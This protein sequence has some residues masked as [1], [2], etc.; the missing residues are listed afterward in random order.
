MNVC[1]LPFPAL[2]D[3]MRSSGLVLRVGPF[4][5]CVHTPFQ[6]LAGMIHHLY[7]GHECLPDREF[8]DFH[9]RVLPCRDRS[10]PWRIRARLVLDG[11]RAHRSFSPEES[12][13]Y[14]EWGLNWCI[15]GHAHQ[16]LILHSAVVAKDDIALIMPGSSGAGKS[17]LCA[18]L[19]YDGWR[20]LSDELGLLCPKTGTIAALARPIVLKDDAI[21][22]FREYA[23]DAL[24]GPVIELRSQGM[25]GALA[26][27]PPESVA[28]A[29]QAA[30]PGVIVFPNF[31][32][33]APGQLTSVTKGQAFLRIAQRSFNFAQLGAL[34]F[35][36]IC[37]LID[38]CDCYEF[39][40]SRLEDALV[41]F[42]NLRLSSSHHAQRVT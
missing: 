36:A 27:V 39:T 32:K 2:A 42:R 22:A 14:F 37:R 13:A 34:G 20:L 26:K 38:Q 12:I 5:V 18:A 33:N 40:Y 9:I 24:W 6:H 10:Q 31:Q 3:R 25:R 8:S 4:T 19:A 30:Y 1:H 21:D 28:K 15:N 23:A 16:Y 35:A 17:T 29:G 41:T 11:I 7:A